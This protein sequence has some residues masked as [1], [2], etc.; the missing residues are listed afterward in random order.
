MVIGLM[1]EITTE[2]T[3]KGENHHMI[4]TCTSLSAMK[5]EDRLKETYAA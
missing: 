3:T 1:V 5:K 2:I 4:T